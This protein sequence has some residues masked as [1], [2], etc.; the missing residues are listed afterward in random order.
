MPSPGAAAREQ[1]FDVVDTGSQALN[2]DGRPPGVIALDRRPLLTC[3]HASASGPRSVKTTSPFDMDS[4]QLKK[5]GLK[6]THP[7]MMILNILTEQHDRHLTAEDVYKILLENGG[8]IGL[9]TV[10]RVLT[11]FETAGLVKRHHF[12]GGQSVFELDEGQHHDHLV[13]LKCGQVVEFY[14][15]GIERR[16]KEIAEERGFDLKDHALI[17]YGTCNRENCT[18][19]SKN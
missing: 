4:N 18:G 8:E 14:D 10:Y 16:Q 13:C 1:H 6:V 9:A 7:R 2:A 5:A 12:D 19:Q 15:E 3:R 17:L 11:Q